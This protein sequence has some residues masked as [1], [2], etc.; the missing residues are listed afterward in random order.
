MAS[1]TELNAKIQDLERQIKNLEQ[2]LSEY[3]NIEKY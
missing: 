1:P 2:K 3:T